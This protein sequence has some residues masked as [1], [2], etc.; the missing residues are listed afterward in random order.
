MA[1]Q[2]WKICDLSHCRTMNTRCYPK[3]SV[4]DHASLK[5]VGGYILSTDIFKAYDRTNLEFIVETMRRM[6]FSQNTLQ[7][8]E[9][10]HR[11]CSTS[12]MVGGGIQMEVSGLWQGDPISGPLFII[13]IE[14]LN[15]KIHESTT[16]ITVGNTVQKA[17]AFMDDVH[18]ISSNVND[19]LL[20]DDYF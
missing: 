3:Q 20:I 1:F 15:W 17:V 2:V 4:I 11:D 16:G 13:S 6:G 14:P 10:L 19:L 8:I 18:A 9:T 12:I 5:D 7:L